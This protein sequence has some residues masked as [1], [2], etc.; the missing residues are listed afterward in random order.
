TLITLF[1]LGLLVYTMVRFRASRHPTPTRTAHNTT[2]EVLWTAI[3]IVILVVIAIPSLRL[4]YFQDRT[5]D[6]GLTL[7]VTGSQWEWG[8][9]YP[10][11]HVEIARSHIIDDADLQ[12]GQV[13]LLEVDNRAVVPV[14]TNI[15]VLVTSRDVIHSFFVPST[16]VQIYGIPGRTNETWLNFE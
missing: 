7:K 10:D 9:E 16:G 14:N 6:A 2:L 15:R 4:L 12:P 5:H 8:F 1:V 11:Q 3:P 13:R